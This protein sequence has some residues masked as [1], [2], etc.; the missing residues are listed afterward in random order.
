VTSVELLAFQDKLTECG[1]AAMP[2]PVALSTVVAGW[3]LLAKVI[4]LLAAPA[5]CGVN[6]TVNP[7]LVPAGMVTGNEM[8]LTLKAP[9]LELT[10][11]TVTFDPVAD[12]VPDP[13]PFEPTVTLPIANVVGF[14]V[15]CPGAAEPVPDKGIVNVGLEAFEVIVT[16]PLAFPAVVGANF[17]LNVAP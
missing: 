6:V 7:T 4:E 15:N 12:R 5:A 1:G 8:P 16:L 3:A 9:L 10:P 17:T 11:V 14:T 13:E 2:V